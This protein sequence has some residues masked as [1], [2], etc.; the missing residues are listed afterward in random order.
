M[1]NRLQRLKK[2]GSQG[3]QTAMT[4]EDR[5]KMETRRQKYGN[6]KVTR[7]N[8]ESFDLFEINQMTNIADV[9]VD[10]DT[11]LTEEQ[12]NKLEEDLRNANSTGRAKRQVAITARKWTGN[13]LYY[14][15]D[16]T[17]DRDSYVRIDLT[18]VPSSYQSNFNKYSSNIAAN[19]VPYE[20]GSDMH[21]SNCP[22][23]YGGATCAERPAGCGSSLTATANWQTTTMTVGDS[24]NSASPRNSVSYCTSW[25]TA[26]A[27]MQVQVRISDIYN[28]QCNYGCP[29]NGLE[30]KVRS[31]KKLVSPRFCCDESKNQIYTSQLNPTPIIAF[32][33]FYSSQFKVDYRYVSAGGISPATPTPGPVTGPPSTCVDSSSSCAQ[34]NSQG[35]CS[36]TFYTTDQKK[37]YCQNT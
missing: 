2:M 33:Q 21:Y 4:A 18:N 25:I 32:N 3:R 8:N 7:P 12:L 30:L 37:Q 34:W 17:V 9:L 10:G 16:S 26:P 14:Y 11:I 23:G 1:A 36:S 27:G 29:F 20:Y 28:G 31:D 19:Y 13:T 15:M 22:L 6:L 5:S 24:S 35:F